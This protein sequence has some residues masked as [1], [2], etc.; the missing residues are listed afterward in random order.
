MITREEKTRKLAQFSASLA[1]AQALVVA[2]NTGLTAAEMADLRAKLHACEGRAQ[3]VKNTL[4]T[5]ALKEEGRFSGICDKLS[6]PLIYG[7]GAD[8]AAVAKVFVDTAKGNPK[9]VIRGGVLPDAESMDGKNVA[10]LAALPSR[11]QLLTT[12][13][14]TLQ[15][16]MTTF[17]RT[18]NQVPTGFARA[19]SALRD[20]NAS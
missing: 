20:K 13:A 6:G 1:G 16:P 4:A 19:L 5:I 8:A 7:V 18:L 15:A 12:L 9:L 14:A 10:A 11:E 2:E 17:V 3:V